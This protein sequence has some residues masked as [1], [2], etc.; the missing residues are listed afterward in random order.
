MTAAQPA[1]AGH[2]SNKHEKILSAVL[3]L[4]SCQTTQKINDVMGLWLQ[5]FAMRS[6]QGHHNIMCVWSKG[7]Y[8]ALCT[9]RQGREEC[10]SVAL[11][12]SVC[13]SVPAVRLW[14]TDAA[15]APGNGT[16]SA[17]RPGAQ[18]A[19]RLALWWSSTWLMEPSTACWLYV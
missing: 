16:C 7:R 18:L 11:P 6:I 3:P 4:T 5:S 15:T 17:P 1:P 10:A 13:Y 2:F 9:G 19:A 12:P 8:V 14:S